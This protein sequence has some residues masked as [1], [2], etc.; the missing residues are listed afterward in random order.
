MDSRDIYVELVQILK[1]MALSPEKQIQILPDFV[2]VP[3][4]IA[5]AYDDIYLMI[6]QIVKEKVISIRIHKLLEDLNQLFNDM[7]GNTFFWSMEYFEHGESWKN[8]RQLASSILEELDEVNDIPDI[9][10]IQWVK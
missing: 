10:F 2:D 3:D 8:V 1:L 9:G 6:P 4:E 7:S 5:L